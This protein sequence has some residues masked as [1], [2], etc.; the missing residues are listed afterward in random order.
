MCKSHMITS[1]MHLK[2]D[3]F[4]QNSPFKTQ[5]KASLTINQ[6][7]LIVSWEDIIV[8]HEFYLYSAPW[9]HRIWPAEAAEL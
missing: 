3:F 5:R 9:E 1:C 6:S 8:W 2:L 7:D 4:G